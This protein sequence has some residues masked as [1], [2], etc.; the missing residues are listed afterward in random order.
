MKAAVLTVSDSVTKGTR[1]DLSGPAVAG[2]LR[3][4]GWDI[5]SGVVPD[6][7]DQISARLVE[8]SDKVD[9]IFTTGGTGLA[10]RDVTPEATRSVI[11]REVPGVAEWMRFQGMQKTPLAIL[12]RAVV[13]T[14]GRCVIVNLPGSPKGALESLDSIL[15]V[16]THI[17]DLLR[18][19]TGHGNSR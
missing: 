4:G 6:E 11:D 18:G 14:R 16:L 19:N 5:S 13:G 8:W 12:S 10:A 9:A 7:A 1:E 2:R 3:D 17:I 15:H